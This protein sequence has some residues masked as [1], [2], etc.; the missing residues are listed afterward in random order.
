MIRSFTFTLFSAFLLYCGQPR[1]QYVVLEEEEQKALAEAR[2]QAI[3]EA[4]A[5]DLTTA[6]S[7]PPPSVRS[8]LRT[9]A[10]NSAARNGQNRND[11]LPKKEPALKLKQPLKPKRRQL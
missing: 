4:K 5:A 3:E 10:P 2:A 6:M 8:I 9:I 11:S 7:N 1:A